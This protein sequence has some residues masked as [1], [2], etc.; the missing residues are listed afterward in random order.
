MK[1]KHEFHFPVFIWIVVYFI[2]SFDGIVLK[3]FGSSSNKVIPNYGSFVILINL[4]REMEKGRKGERERN[5]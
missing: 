3:L 1:I 5:K 4:K 2:S